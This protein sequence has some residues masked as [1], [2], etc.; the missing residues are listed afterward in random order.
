M[1]FRIAARSTDFPSPRPEM[2]GVQYLPAAPIRRGSGATCSGSDSCAKMVLHGFVWGHQAVFVLSIKHRSS[3]DTIL[4][5]AHALADRRR[6]FE[7]DPRIELRGVRVHGG[8]TDIRVIPSD[9]W[10]SC[11]LFRCTRGSCSSGGWH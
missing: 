7:S 2:L 4:Q 6:R 9:G 10:R 8:N 5:T 3:S 11:L 1:A